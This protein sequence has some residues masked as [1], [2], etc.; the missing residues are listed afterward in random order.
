VSTHAERRWPAREAHL[1]EISDFVAREAYALGADDDAV[2]DM[3]LVAEEVATNI[4]RYGYPEGQA[5]EVVVRVDG[6][7]DAMRI[8][9]MDDATGY[10][11]DC[12]PAP[13]TTAPVAERPIG[14]LGWHLIRT[15]VDEVVHRPLDPRG[16]ELI[17]TRRLGRR[18]PNPGSGAA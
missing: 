6:A 5:G 4:F 18:H 2:S 17:L 9:F 10:R 14:G 1:R 16:N 8:T 7:G 12:I 3:R 11:P 13:D 15:L